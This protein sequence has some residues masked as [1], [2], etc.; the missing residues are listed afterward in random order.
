[1]QIA[2]QSQI[3][4]Q[5][6]VLQLHYHLSETIT[7]ERGRKKTGLGS[8]AVELCDNYLQVLRLSRTVKYWSTARHRICPTIS[9]PVSHPF[10]PSVMEL[11]ESDTYVSETAA[12]MGAYFASQSSFASRSSPQAEPWQLLV[13][14][15]MNPVTSHGFVSPECPRTT[16]MPLALP[17]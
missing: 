1:M 15:A 3:Q 10:G 8:A 9:G 14:T 6:L 4:S 16:P 17:A 11:A 7:P 12:E 2:S 5:R 13:L